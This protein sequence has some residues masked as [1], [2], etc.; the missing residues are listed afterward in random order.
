MKLPFQQQHMNH[1]LYHHQKWWNRHLA[2]IYKQFGFLVR[3]THILYSANIENSILETSIWYRNLT[4]AA[5][6]RYEGHLNT[7]F[8]LPRSFSDW[9]WEEWFTEI[10]RLVTLSEHNER[11][12]RRIRSIFGEW[13]LDREFWNR[14]NGFQVYFDILWRLEFKS[15]LRHSKFA[16]ETRQ[17]LLQ[18]FCLTWLDCRL[19]FL[20]HGF[21][22]WIFF[23]WHECINNLKPEVRP[24]VEK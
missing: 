20:V 19:H 16:T 14:W 17:E 9:F 13:N 1:S 8:T 2:D 5:R 11:S 24:E 7:S 10:L 23:S 12:I 3:S 22:N 18:C 15:V 6:N 4:R 21:P